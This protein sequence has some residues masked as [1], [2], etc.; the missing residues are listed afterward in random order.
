MCAPVCVCSL[1]GRC[2]HAYMI[3]AR[4]V[5]SEEARDRELTQLLL[6]HVKG[7]AAV[8]VPG[9]PCEIQGKPLSRLSVPESPGLPWEQFDCWRCP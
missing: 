9:W 3:A 8:W 6:L 5:L 1:V 4:M 7:H 2:L